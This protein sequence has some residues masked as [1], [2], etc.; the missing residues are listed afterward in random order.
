MRASIRLVLSILC[1]SVFPVITVQALENP[2]K[3]S[4]ASSAQAQGEN[5]VEGTV[6]SITEQTLVL[7]RMTTSFI[8]SPMEPALSPAKR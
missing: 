5:V 2:H 8:F 3:A 4:S 1:V 7:S 6:V